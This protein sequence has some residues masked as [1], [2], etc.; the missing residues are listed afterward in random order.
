MK[1]TFVLLSMFALGVLA[2]FYGRELQVI[3]EEKLTDLT[4]IGVAVKDKQPEE[5]IPS[6]WAGLSL[7][8]VPEPVR[9]VLTAETEGVWVVGVLPGSPAE[10]AGIKTYDIITKVGSQ[11]VTDGKE[12]TDEIQKSEGKE[13]EFTVFRAGEL[14]T[15]TLTPTHMPEEMKAR[16]RALQQ[17]FFGPPMG[18]GIHIQ[19]PRRGIEIQV[20]EGG[21][22]G[23]GIKRLSPENLPP[24]VRQRLEEAF[25]GKIFENGDDEEEND[26]SEEDAS[27]SEAGAEEDEDH[28][29]IVKKDRQIQL[30]GSRPG[31][32]PGRNLPPAAPGGNVRSSFAMSQHMMFSHNGKPL[33]I[34]VTR[35]NDQPARIK[36]TWE[37]KEYESNDETLDVFPEEIRGK[38]EDILKNGG[39]KVRVAP[40][41]ISIFGGGQTEDAQDAEESGELKV[42]AD[43]VIDLKK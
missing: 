5:A 35:A 22:I 31:N 20:P 24:E 3:G 37:G 40:G 14:K 42:K 12:I 43:K 30:P 6:W 7:A 17:D 23:G 38:I 28:D 9:A 41:G 27:R 10:K 16:Y 32:F 13:L 21:A 39:A 4:R 36:A 1:K 34:T 29:I 2:G 15:L 18:P 19:I 8:P 25:G 33:E 26:A 11:E